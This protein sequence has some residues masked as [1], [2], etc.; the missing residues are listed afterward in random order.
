VTNF[1]SVILAVNWPYP[2]NGPVPGTFCHERPMLSADVQ[3]LAIAAGCNAPVFSRPWNWTFSDER[4]WYCGGV[5]AIGTVLRKA[6]VLEPIETPITPAEN[7]IT[8]MEV[9]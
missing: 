8:T 3:R 6:G 4:I 1:G 5:K 2:D 9:S 7:R